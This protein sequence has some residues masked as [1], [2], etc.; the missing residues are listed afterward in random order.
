MGVKLSMEEITQQNAEVVQIHLHGTTKNVLDKSDNHSPLLLTTK[1]TT[2]GRTAWGGVH[3][4]CGARDEYYAKFYPH[5]CNRTTHTGV[6]KLSTGV[7][8][9]VM[10]DQQVN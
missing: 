8:H 7:Q 3:C 1:R 4:S 2:L 6:G 10:Y 5:R 9:G